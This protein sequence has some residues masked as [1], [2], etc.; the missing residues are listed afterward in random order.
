[1]RTEKS[2]KT[3]SGNPSEYDGWRTSAAFFAMQTGKL[4]NWEGKIPKMPSLSG[5]SAAAKA[6]SVEVHDT[7]R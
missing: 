4:A 2:L 7:G 1:M 3:F 6:G 5:M